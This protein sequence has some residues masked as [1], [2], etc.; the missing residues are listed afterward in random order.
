MLDFIGLIW[1]QFIL[2]PMVNSLV[3]LYVIFFDNFDWGC[4]FTNIMHPC[5]YFEFMHLISIE[6]DIFVLILIFGE[7]FCKC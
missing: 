6:S 7:D 3:F 4:N 1:D 2:G 5:R